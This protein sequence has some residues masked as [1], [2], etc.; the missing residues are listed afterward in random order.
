MRPVYRAGRCRASYRSLGGEGG[1]PRPRVRTSRD[2]LCAAKP[3]YARRAILVRLG[4]RPAPPPPAPPTL[5]TR[6]FLL[7]LI[8]L[9][10]ATLGIQ[11]QATVV[12]YQLYEIT[13]DPL[14]LGA[15]GLAEALPFV[16]LALLGG[17]VADAVD[18]RRVVVAAFAV[19][20]LAAAV[21]LALTWRRQ[22]LSAGLLQLGIYAVIVLGGVCRAFL[23]PSRTALSAQIVPR[24]AVPQGHRLAHGRVPAVRHR[25]PGLRRAA[26]RLGRGQRR[27]P[28]H[29][30]PAAGGAGD[31]AG[32]ARPPAGDAAPRARRC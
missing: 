21:L 14:S 31:H 20:S 17:H 7:F 19:M 30:R 2:Q 16:S 12:G 4:R 22:V 18:R 11:I 9:G 5:F 15:I 29:H 25:R 32:R 23:Q 26:V 6:D 27:L 10:A 3:R 24:R 1:G 8:G 28:R 13:R